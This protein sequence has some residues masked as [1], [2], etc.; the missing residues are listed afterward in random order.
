VG[1]AGQGSR[2]AFRQGMTRPRHQR[3][4]CRG[5]VMGDGTPLTSWTVAAGAAFF[6]LAGITVG[7]ASRTTSLFSQDAGVLV[8]CVDD[9]GA[10]DR[11][12]VAASAGRDPAA[13]HGWSLCQCCIR[14]CS[15]PGS[16]SP[17]H[18]AEHHTSARHYQ[19]RRSLA[20]GRQRSASFRHGNRRVGAGSSR[21]IISHPFVGALPLWVPSFSGRFGA[22]PDN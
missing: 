3:L 21:R 5:P 11:P 19:D 12:A 6:V 2:R 8:S 10:D 13:S 15:L 22:P 14:C 17:G 4:P 20:T 9:H 18:G 7:V 16:C 1:A